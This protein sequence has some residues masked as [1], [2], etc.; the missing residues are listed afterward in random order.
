MKDINKRVE[1]L[2]ERTLSTLEFPKTHDRIYR[3]LQRLFN[4]ANE[5]NLRYNTPEYRI[6]WRKALRRF[7]EGRPP[8]K[9]EDTS[10][11][12]ALNW[13]WIIQCV[14]LKNRDVIIVSRDA[15]Y[16]LSLEGKGYANNWLAEEIK[17]RT[18]K[19]RELIMVDRL[20]EA[21][22]LLSIPVTSE[23]ITSERAIMHASSVTRESVIED[24]ISQSISE[25]VDDDPISSLIAQTNADGWGC[26]TFDLSNIRYKTGVWTANVEFTF[27]GK[28][29]DE[30]PWH[31]TQIVGN[32]A[33]TIDEEHLVSFHSIEAE[34]ESDDDCMDPEDNSLDLPGPP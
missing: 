1:K 12:D 22:K 2:K 3:T 18:N 20:S 32:C 34:I 11:G 23:E 26:D 29:D 28:Q 19:L 17:E 31:G 30:K 4:N 7:L 9:K 10:A 21:L 25:L 16:G 5:L 8:R 27:S 24:L 33:V 13:E 14:K 15:D 6:T